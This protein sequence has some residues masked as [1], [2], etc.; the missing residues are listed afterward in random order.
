MRYQNKVR[1][2]VHLEIHGRTLHTLQFNGYNN[3]MGIFEYNLMQ[4]MTIASAH[5]LTV[6]FY[7]LQWKIEQH[8]FKSHFVNSS[9]FT[10]NLRLA[11]SK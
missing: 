10:I 3:T 2:I 8:Y 9:L 5:K 7:E 4:I 1:Y 6:Q 11:L